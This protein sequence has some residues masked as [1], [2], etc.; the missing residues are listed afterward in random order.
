VL[1]AKGVGAVLVNPQL[2]RK[3]SDLGRLFVLPALALRPSCFAP[4]LTAGIFSVSVIHQQYTE[5][6][7]EVEVAPYKMV[8]FTLQAK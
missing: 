6:V 1:F 4:N 2:A 5:T 3:P 7:R 8:D